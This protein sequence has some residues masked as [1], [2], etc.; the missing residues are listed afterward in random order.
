MPIT[1]DEMLAARD[2]RVNIQ[3]DL[4]A[5]AGPDFCLVCL[6]LNIAG[7][8]KRTPMS[9][10]LFDRGTAEFN[11]LGFKVAEHIEIDEPTGT[12]GFWLLKE[13]A[14]NV[15]EKLEQIEEDANNPASRLY[16]FDVLINNAAIGDSGSIADISVDRI[17][18]VFE[19]NVFSNIKITQVAL[20]N[21]IEN[22]RGRVIF[23]SS[24][25]GRI[26]IPFLGPY[27]ATKFAIEGFASSLRKE[28]KKLDDVNIQ[29]GIIEPGA[30]ATGFNKEN[31]E[32]KYEWMYKD[33]YFK[34]KWK[35]IKDKET[36][37]WNFIEKKNFDSIIK[38]YIHS[39]EDRKLKFRYTAPKTQSFIIQLQ[40]I[41]G[42]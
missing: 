14:A 1:L 31:N 26:S 8:V 19:T 15:K 23:L 28:M 22:K 42:L 35:D 12:E 24:L 6:T 16:D 41:F 29:I 17:E 18:N 5:D 33:S 3:R 40:R 9:R 36:R 39:V 25:A 20:K 7:D 38:Q 11:K 4:L 34:Y 27:C 2:R 13:D 21:M 10:M 37:Y 30:Y 32:K